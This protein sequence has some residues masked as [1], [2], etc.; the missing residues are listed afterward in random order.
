M[1]SSHR[2]SLSFLR[3]GRMLGIVEPT[4]T[5]PSQYSQSYG[6]IPTWRR[7]HWSVAVSKASFALGIFAG[8][9]PILRPTDLWRLPGR[10]YIGGPDSTCIKAMARN[11][12]YVQ[13]SGCGPVKLNIVWQALST[14]EVKKTFYIQRAWDN[15]CTCHV[16]KPESWLRSFKRG[17]VT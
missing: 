17:E 9:W 7:G 8:P 6:T 5:G 2:L 10:E 11:V 13:E 4:T 16:L 14:F 15:P 3:A 1:P 12:I